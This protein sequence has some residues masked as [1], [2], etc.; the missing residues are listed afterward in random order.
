MQSAVCVIFSNLQKLMFFACGL[1]F[2][3]MWCFLFREKY[4][5]DFSSKVL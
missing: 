1:F 4:N 3:N 5:F 2:D